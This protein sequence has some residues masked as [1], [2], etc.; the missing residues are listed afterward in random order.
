MEAKELR[1]GNFTYKMLQSGNGRI[2]ESNITSTDLLRIEEERIFYYEPIPIT[3]EWLLKF[4][5]ER[6][7][8]NWKTLNLHFA[9]IG[10]ERL[11]LTV[12][13]FDK[14]SIYLPHIKYVHQLQNLYFSLTG[15][16]LIIKSINKNNFNNK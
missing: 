3:E 4:G 7:E 14:D 10:W 8:N 16:E 5:F 11:A 6:Q 13:S 2:I 15:E 9:T 12:L 1:I